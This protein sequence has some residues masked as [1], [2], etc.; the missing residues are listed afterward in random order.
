M[1]SNLN[2]VLA[3]GFA[4][5]IVRDCPDNPARSERY[6]ARHKYKKTHVWTSTESG[7]KM[8]D[9]QCVFCG[10]LVQKVPSFS[11]PAFSLKV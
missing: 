4:N 8:T 9:Y 6:G 1:N 2:K 11:I 5:A 10:G 7:E 3:V